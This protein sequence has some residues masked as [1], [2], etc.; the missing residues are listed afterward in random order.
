MGMTMSMQRLHPEELLRALGDP[1]RGL[2]LAAYVP[3]P[4]PQ[5]LIAQLRGK[6]AAA[7]PQQRSALEQKLQEAGNPRSLGLDKSWHLVHYV[8]SGSRS[9]DIAG[10]GSPATEQIILGIHKTAYDVGYGPALYLFADEVQHCASVLA[11]ISDASLRHRLDGSK[12]Y[13]QEI[14]GGGWSGDAEEGQ[15][16]LDVIA[17][18][19]SFFVDAAAS[20]DCL[21][22][23]V[24]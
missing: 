22:K 14:Y 1:E 13:Q 12:K 2:R 16:I 3:L 21:F 17:T 23:S 20:G 24:T 11:S 10:P 6:L 8:L 9:L 4:M 18:M 7:P 15:F 19:R 5:A